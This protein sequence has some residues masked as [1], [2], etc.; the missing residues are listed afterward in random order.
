MKI[1]KLPMILGSWLG[2]SLLLGG[3]AAQ[4]GGQDTA[5][6]Q[7]GQT[8]SVRFAV[9]DSVRPVTLEGRK[10]PAA[11]AAGSVT[12]NVGRALMRGLRAPFGGP[13]AGEIVGSGAAHAG[14]AAAEEAMSRQ[15]GV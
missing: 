6:A 7:T 15:K 5:R 2:L 14:G 11:N 8:L 3:C 9:I 4:P 12:S 1:L 10:I 13:S